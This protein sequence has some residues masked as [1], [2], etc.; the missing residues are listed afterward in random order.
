M[1]VSNAPAYAAVSQGNT[2]PGPV[3]N[4]PKYAAVSNAGNYVKSSSSSSSSSINQQKINEYHKSMMGKTTPSVTP[5][6]S[7]W[8]C[9]EW[10]FFKW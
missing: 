8:W 7:N 4:I 2:N 5:S 3:N 10:R 1:N 9:Q 6:V